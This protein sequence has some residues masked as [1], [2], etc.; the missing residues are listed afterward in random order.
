MRVCEVV[1][2]VTVKITV[3][4]YVT[5]CGLVQAEVSEESGTGI[6]PFLKWA[7]PEVLL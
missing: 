5:P 4:W 2:E 6:N 1:L 3:V 7:S